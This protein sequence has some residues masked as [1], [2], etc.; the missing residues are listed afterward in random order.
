MPLSTAAQANKY[1]WAADRLKCDL[2]LASPISALVGNKLFEAAETTIKS[3]IKTRNVIEELEVQVKF[4]DLRRFV[5]LDKIDFN[6]VLEIRKKA[7]KFRDWLQ[8]E[9]DRD[10]DAISAYHHEVAKETGFSNV[11]RYSRGA[12]LSTTIFRRNS[13]KPTT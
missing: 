6:R 8:S 9:G 1:V 4:P 2:Y 5:N 10:R 13:S 7:K 3:R 12:G 11:A